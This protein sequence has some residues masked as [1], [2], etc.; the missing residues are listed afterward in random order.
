MHEMQILSLTI[1]SPC[2]SLCQD[3]GAHRLVE[4]LPLEEASSFHTHITPQ[5]GNS[6]NDTRKGFLIT[7]PEHSGQFLQSHRGHSQCVQKHGREVS[8]RQLFQSRKINLKHTKRLDDLELL[9]LQFFKR[10]SFAFFRIPP[11]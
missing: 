3:P 1:L 5:C 11:S 8:Q 10:L 2:S 6:G 4:R 9:H 7:V